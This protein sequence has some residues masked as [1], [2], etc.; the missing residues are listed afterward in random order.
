MRIDKSLCPRQA[1]AVDDARMVQRVTENRVAVAC[2][3]R[4]NTDVG[5][6][7]GVEDQRGFAAFE[8]GDTPLQLFVQRH[9]ARDQTRRARA[10]TVAID[11]LL[12][13]GG[14]LGMIG[15]TEVIVGG[16]IQNFA[17]IDRQDRS[18]V[19]LNGPQRAI[20]RGILKL[21][22]LPLNKIFGT[23][24]LEL[25]NIHMAAS[26]HDRDARS[27]YILR[28][29]LFRKESP[30]GEANRLYRVLA[31]G[32]LLSCRPRGGRTRARVRCFPANAE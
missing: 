21:L 20:E 13:C 6:K 31:C 17:A 23:H 26:Q 14:E 18:L 16:K 3:S 2:Q 15:E 4:E 25:D 32:G 5:L 7:S 19:A 12:G 28:D 1:A 22:Q 10:A 11:R 24:G 9:V 30:A 27:G 8:F 29:A